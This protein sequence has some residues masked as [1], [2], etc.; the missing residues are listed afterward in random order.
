MLDYAWFQ[1]RGYPIGS[2]SVESAN[3]LVVERRLKGAGMHWA[4]AHVNPMVALRTVACRDRWAEAWPQIVHHMRHHV[5]QRRVQQRRATRASPPPLA[6][7]PLPCTADS[8]LTPVPTAGTTCAP[9]RTPRLKSDGTQGGPRC[10]RV[11]CLLQV[12]RAQ[13]DGVRPFV[14]A[15]C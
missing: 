2:G 11:A 4:L 8:P 7:F 13:R 10:Y 9:R 6:C 15:G 5:W 12:V 14:Q 1:A 3:T